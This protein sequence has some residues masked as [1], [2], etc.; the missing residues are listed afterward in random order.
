MRVL[1][2]AALVM[3]TGIWASAAEPGFIATRGK[4]LVTGDGQPAAMR[5]INFG[6]WLQMETWIPSLAPEPEDHLR[7]LADEAGIAPAFDAAR[8]SAGRFNDDVMK[9]GGYL[10]RLLAAVDEEAGPAKGA[11]YRKMVEKEPPIVDASTLDRVWRGRFGDDGAQT[12]WDAYHDTWIVEEEFRRA[13][14]V[15]F[16]FVR[17][18][19]WYRWFEDDA[20]PYEYKEYGFRYLDRAVS[21][22]RAHGLYLLLDLHGAPGG[23]NPWSHTGELSR[24]ELFEDE[25]CQKRTYALWRHIADRYKD[26]PTVFAYGCLNEP[27]SA[28]GVEDWAEVHNGIYE[29]IRSVDSN[30]IIMMEDGYKLEE[31]PWMEKGFFPEPSEYGWENVMYS[32][33]FYQMPSQKDY[34]HRCGEV[35]RLG[36]MEQE[37]CGVP[38]YIGEFNSLLEDR[39]AAVESMA[40]FFARFNAKGWSWSPWTFKF[41]GPGRETLWGVY[42]YEGEWVTPNNHRDSHEA[43]LETIRKLHARNFT[44]VAPYADVLTRALAGRN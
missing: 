30:H 38:I 3:C 10:E 44:V 34:A 35:V 27:F 26:E 8:K 24:G 1:L 9:Y 40:H 23:Q 29:A 42:Q 14:E 2:L 16:A 21:W 15:G 18:P 32:I 41:T 20:K 31:K 4:A 19:L 7:A 33:H 36:T 11:Q 28:D 5:G 25:E 17:I 43:L 6:S 12:L 39:A 22:A 37:R 13:K